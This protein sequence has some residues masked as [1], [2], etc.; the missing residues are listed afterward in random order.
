MINVLSLAS[1]ETVQGNNCPALDITH[2]PTENLI[3][4][5]SPCLHAQAKGRRKNVQ[6]SHTFSSIPG[7]KHCSMKRKT[8]SPFKCTKCLYF[9]DHNT[10]SVLKP[11][12]L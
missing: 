11:N 3:D 2:I 9:M 10:L 4:Y 8:L 12:H 6:F 5:M 7:Y 1:N